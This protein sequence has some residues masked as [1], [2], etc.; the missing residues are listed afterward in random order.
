MRNRLAPAQHK[1][2]GNVTAGSVPQPQKCSRYGKSPPHGRQKCPAND[3]ICHR[4]HKRGHYKRCC[5]TEVTSS[6]SIRDSRRSEKEAYL[7]TISANAIG[8]K[9]PWLVKAKLN[10]AEVEFKVDTGADVTVIP[11]RMYNPTRDRKLQ[12]S[13]LPLSGPTGE[14]LRVHGQFSGNPLRHASRCRQDIYVVR[15]LR[16]PPLGKPA[17][18]AL[19]VVALV[20]P[21]QKLDVV[22]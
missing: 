1:P 17:L 19:N 16:R 18:E 2:A 20:E 7:R 15:D 5:K 11:E 14:T 13:T 8:A 21:I 22:P 6:T 3:V 4:C 10:G 9:A 12:P